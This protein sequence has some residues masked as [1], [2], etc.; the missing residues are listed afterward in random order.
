MTTKRFTIKPS[1]I[2]DDVTV[3]IDNQKEYTF[4]V[5]DSTLN[6]MFCKV[7]NE[8]HETIGRLK[9]N[10]DELLS[11]DIEEELLKENEQLK[12]AYTQ[13]KHRHS[14]LHD[15]C[16]DAECDRDSY[17][18]DIES[19]EKENEQLRT[20]NNAYIQDI[21]VFKEENTHLKLE[22]EQLQQRNDRQAKRLAELYELMAKKDWESLTEIID[23][24]KRCEE[25][26][27]REWRTYE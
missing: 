12:Q 1:M 22:N 18:K 7:L 13:L 17:R 24:F 8:Q 11:V 2:V 14:L 27:Q 21:E 10:I 9:E 6:Y 19:L 4:P 20:K 26:L 25:Q 3:I 5:L 16:I 15:E 23:D